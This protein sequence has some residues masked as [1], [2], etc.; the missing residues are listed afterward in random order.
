M[1][2]LISALLLLTSVSA[3]ASN[4]SDDTVGVVVVGL[5]IA[6][7]C[8]YITF[9]PVFVASN[10]KHPNTFAIFIVVLF[11]GWTLLGW[12]L[13]LVWAVSYHKPQPTIVYVQSNK[14][15]ARIKK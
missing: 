7:I 6:A 13:A 5:M 12:V 1:K 3:F 9:L 10:R 11:L 4:S 15:N 2:Y 14:S 8:I